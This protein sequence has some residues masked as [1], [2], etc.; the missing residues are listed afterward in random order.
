MKGSDMERMQTFIISI[1]LMVCSLHAGETVLTVDA[2]EVAGISGF[3]EL[4]NQPVV[5]AEDGAT[6]VKG[7]KRFGSSPV[8]KWSAGEAGA[9]VC[10]AV[11]RSVLV[12]FP[13]SATAIAAKIKQGYSIAKVELVLPFKHTEFFPLRYDRPVGLSF[14]GDAWKKTPPNWH[15]QAWLLRKP[16]RADAQSGPTYNAA[17]NGKFYWKKYGAQDEREDR[18]PEVFGPAEVSRS[19]PEGLMDITKCFTDPAYGK[20]LGRRLRNFAERGMLLRKWEVYDA[21]YW[22][23]GYEW[24]VATGQR[25]IHIKAPKLKITFRPV[26]GASVK[27]PQAVDLESL[28]GGKST[29]IV[30]TETEFAELARKFSFKR[31]PWTNDWQW[32]RLQE[33]LKYGK[34]EGFPKNYAEYLAWV[35]KFISMNPRAWKGFTA[36]KMG[37]EYAKYSTAIPEPAKDNIKLYWWAWLMP[38]RRYDSLVHGHIG[39]KEAMSYYAKTRD[40][41]GN[42]STYR[43]YCHSMGTT[44]FNSWATTGAVFGGWII[45]DEGIMAEGRKGY[46]HWMTRTWTWMDGSSQESVD[47]YYLAH[48]LGPLK[49]IADYAP[50]AAERLAGRLNMEKHVD[51]LISVWHPHLRRFIS[52]SYRTG[53]AYPLYLQE[54][55]NYIMHTISKDGA[56]TDSDGKQVAG[57][58]NAFAL[59]LSP[60]QVALQSQVNPWATDADAELVDNKV[61]PYESTRSFVRWGSYTKTPLWRK[62]YLGHHYGLASMDICKNENVPVMA[63]WRRTDAKVDSYR[64]LGTLLAR[65]GVNDTEFLDSLYHGSKKFNPNGSVGVQGSPTITVQGK[66]SAIILGSPARQL[67]HFYGRVMP[68]EIKSMQ[69]SLALFSFEAKPSWKIYVDAKPVVSLPVRVKFGQRI[70]IHDGVTYLGII[71]IPATDLGGR[72]E[73]VVISTKGEPTLMQGGGKVKVTLTIDAY[74][75]H[76]DIPLNLS[77]NDK[78]GSDADMP[79]DTVT[80]DAMD[81]AVAGYVVTL[82]DAQEYKD[83]AAFQRAFMTTPFSSRWEAEKSIFHVSY[84]S[85]DNLL[86]VGYNPV[87]SLKQPTDNAL[88]YRRF[89]GKWPYLSK[90]VC[91]DTTTIQQA[92]TGK[93][94]KHGAVLTTAPGNMAYLKGYPKTGIYVGINPYRN[95]VPF[96]LEIPGGII[97]ESDGK[98]GQARVEVAKGRIVIDCV[99]PAEARN[100]IVKGM[101]E[102]AVLLNG[103]VQKP[104]ATDEGLVIALIDSDDSED[105]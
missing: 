63:Q 91:R 10:D 102:C 87:A 43:T 86:E 82:G 20:D 34:G 64:H 11:H 89:G 52:S 21:R 56:L 29:A 15:M 71:P 93:L 33:L 104:V 67:K 88:P 69:M 45:G 97:L 84:G 39:G 12:R 42:F 23:G 59:E 49:V 74:N 66:N 62:S 68:A 75:Y 92:V 48:T 46:D 94:K 77:G 50:G 1:T 55:L 53:I 37:A 96:R 8:G 18:F 38:D 30:P 6:V 54:G 76:S 47:H 99:E 90:G 101:A 95:P 31:P 100:I 5:L 72:G 44:N 51:E 85:G 13:E 70:T 103:K 65:Y 2:A 41:R 73:E 25:G 9:I 60:A 36:G 3:R 19:N 78:S 57:R 22:T 32:T 17:I 16:W 83:F 4:W 80:L 24:G 28:A 7:S 81:R 27:L 105:K 61:L 40:W 98:L 14:L 35:D 58:E 26:A 79:L